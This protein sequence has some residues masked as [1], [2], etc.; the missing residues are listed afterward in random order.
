[1]WG[2][3]PPG[4]EAGRPALPLIMPAAQWRPECV[5][6]PWSAVGKLCSTP[7]SPWLPNLQADGVQPTG[8][9]YT[10]LISAFGKAG[11]VEEALRVYQ[12]CG[13]W[14]VWKYQPIM[15]FGNVRV[16]A[17]GVLSCLQGSWAL[18]RQACCAGWHHADM[19]RMALT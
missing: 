1:M 3:S 2:R 9:T 5:A 10:S 7:P 17:A 18:A 4:G 6:A 16:C 12:V 19:E 11:Q 8:T 15:P 13:R 14:A